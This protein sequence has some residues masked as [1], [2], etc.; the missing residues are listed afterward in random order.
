MLKLDKK[1]TNLSDYLRRFICNTTM[2]QCGGFELNDTRT[3]PDIPSIEYLKKN[4]LDNMYRFVSTQLK[5]TTG[6]ILGIEHDQVCC[7]PVE[8]TKD[9][10]RFHRFNQQIHKDRNIKFGKYLPLYQMLIS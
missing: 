3:N 6:I 9:D 5:G 10:I 8:N 2:D 7:I 1:D 4:K